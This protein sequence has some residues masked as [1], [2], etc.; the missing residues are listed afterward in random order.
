VDKASSTEYIQAA[1]GV[2]T[3]A[4]FVVPYDQETTAEY[5]SFGDTVTLRHTFTVEFWC[6]LNTAAPG[7]AFTTARDAGYLAMV[8]LLDK[9]GTG[10]VL[11][12]NIQFRERVSPEPVIVAN[13]PWLVNILRVPVENEV[14]F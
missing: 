11:D 2:R 6:P 14:S 10:Y 9:D 7:T 4:A 5:V 8:K 3:C 12:R 13:V 1:T